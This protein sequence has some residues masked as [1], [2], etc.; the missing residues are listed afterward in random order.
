[1][2]VNRNY[3]NYLSYSESNPK[4]IINNFMDRLKST[5]L[6]LIIFTKYKQ[7]NEFKLFIIKI[8]RLNFNFDLA[9]L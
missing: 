2:A 6:I 1:M 8:L 5:K 7:K 3:K 4:N 9:I